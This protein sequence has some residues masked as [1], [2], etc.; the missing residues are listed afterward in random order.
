LKTDRGSDAKG[1]RLFVGLDIGSSFL[2]YVV[3]DAKGNVL[4]SPEPVMHFANPLGA[5]GAA[6]RDITERFGRDAVVSTALT[7]S[8]SE[9]WARAHPR[10]PEVF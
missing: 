4:Y 3:L 5:V 7:G 6:W 1:K 8:A 2:H 10:G 9:S